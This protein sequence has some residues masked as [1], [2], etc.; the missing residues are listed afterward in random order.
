MTLPANRQ[1]LRVIALLPRIVREFALVV[2][3][4]KTPSAPV[5][6]LLSMLADQ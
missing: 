5:Q 6:A 2:A 4:H 1:G 3:P